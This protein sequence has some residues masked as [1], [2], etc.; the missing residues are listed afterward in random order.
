MLSQ[1][2]YAAVVFLV[3]SAFFRVNDVVGAVLQIA[4]KNDVCHA[5]RD[6]VVKA[7][8]FHGGEQHTVGVFVPLYCYKIGHKAFAVSIAIVGDQIFVFY[9]VIAEDC[10]DCFVVYGEIVEVFLNACF[11]G[12]AVTVEPDGTDRNERKLAYR[13]DFLFFVVRNVC[14]GEVFDGGMYV[15][16][17]KKRTYDQLHIGLGEHVR[18]ALD[19]AEPVDPPIAVVSGKR[20][21]P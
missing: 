5:R 11:D 9:L 19:C 20:L 12:L 4:E 21:Y 14:R 1:I 15:F 7:D 3:E 6:L 13:Y 16:I 8:H 2:Q 10:T 17:P 18:V